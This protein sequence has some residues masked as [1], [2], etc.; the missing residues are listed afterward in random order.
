MSKQIKQPRFRTNSVYRKEGSNALYTVFR[1]NNGEQ[2]DY[3]VARMKC[4]YHVA[5]LDC[6]GSVVGSYADWPRFGSF[7]DAARELNLKYCCMREESA[8]KSEVIYPYV[9][10][11]EYCEDVVAKKPRSRSR[12]K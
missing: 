2:L 10:S 6:Y 12:K 7:K 11:A 4:D 8:D 3:Y 1:T 9:D 5:K